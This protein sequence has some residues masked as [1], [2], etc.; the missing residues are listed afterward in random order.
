MGNRVTRSR[1]SQLRVACNIKYQKIPTDYFSRALPPSNSS[2][3]SI[4]QFIFFGYIVTDSRF[5]IQ[6][7]DYQDFADD[8]SN[9]DAGREILAETRHQFGACSHATCRRRF[10][11]C[12]TPCMCVSWQRYPLSLAHSFG[13]PRSE[14]SIRSCSFVLSSIPLS[15]SLP[16]SPPL[17]PPLP[18]VFFSRS[19]RFNGCTRV[20]DRTLRVRATA[21]VREAPRALKRLM[22]ARIALH[23]FSENPFAVARASSSSRAPRCVSSSFVNRTRDIAWLFGRVRCR[24]FSPAAWISARRA[25]RREKRIVYCK[26]Y[27]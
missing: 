7:L 21:C 3:R 6:D 23:V 2:F 15:F 12:D 19:P 14:P 4:S 1:E 5:W 24:G 8:L 13:S 17:S 9:Q 10:A 26:H 27:V 25:N 22:L 11:F 20:S 16:F 18:F